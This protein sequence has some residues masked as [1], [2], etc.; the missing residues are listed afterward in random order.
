ML[1]RLAACCL[2]SQRVWTAAELFTRLDELAG[3]DVFMPLYESR[4][5][6]PGMPD[7]TDLYAELGIEPTSDTAVR[8]TDAGRRSAVREAIMAP[9][10]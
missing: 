7:L 10:P 9:K 6:E 5:R 4:M 2:P 1:G 8:L 3:A